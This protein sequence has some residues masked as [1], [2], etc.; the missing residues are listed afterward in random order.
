MPTGTN[1]PAVGWYNRTVIIDAVRRASE[2]ISRVELVALTRLSAQTV[3][4]V[5]AALVR[6]GVFE[7][8]GRQGA[9]VGKPR[10]MLRLRAGHTYSV[11]VHIDPTQIA[12]VLVDLTGASVAHRVLPLV[13]IPD[14]DDALSEIVAAVD[15]LTERH[16]IPRDALVGVGVAVPGPI[17]VRSG[18]VLDP[19]FLPQ[20]GHADVLSRLTELFDLPVL[21]EKDV[22]A[23][24]VGERWSNTST[25]LSNMLF[26]YYGTGVGAGLVVGNQVIRGATGNAGDVGDLLIRSDDVANLGGALLPTRVV[27]LARER[28]ILP[29]ST[30]GAAVSPVRDDFARIVEAAAGGDGAAREVMDELARDIAAAV[31]EIVNLLDLDSIVFGGP[32]WTLIA[33]LVGDSVAQRVRESKNIV[34]THPISFFSA[35]S[36]DQ[37]I[38]MGAAALV[39]DRHFAP[40]ADGLLIRR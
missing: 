30:P 1:L 38:A 12:T 8:S 18:V 34:P 31:T 20:W 15:E 40:Q 25:D 14:L 7:E 37:V 28:G 22:T 29:A 36:G 10:T 26:L 3:S 17:D 23:A 19:P 35:S 16:G 33:D 32:Y 27:E 5:C 9:G 24:V 4:K 11:G 6:E 13:E 39:L 21:L 2:G